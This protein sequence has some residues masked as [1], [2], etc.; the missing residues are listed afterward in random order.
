M[1]FNTLDKWINYVR[2]EMKW[3]F[4]EKN[5]EH[6]NRT[7]FPNDYYDKNLISEIEKIF[8]KEKIF[9]WAL[10]LERRFF[11]YRFIKS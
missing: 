2:F 8:G 4:D 11:P 5:K 6:D 3:W 10:Y 9:Y 1:E 7:F